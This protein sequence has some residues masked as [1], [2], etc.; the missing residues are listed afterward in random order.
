M[1]V[2]SILKHILSMRDR[3]GVKKIANAAEARDNKLGTIES[4]R[5]RSRLWEKFKHLKAGDM[6][7][8]HKDIKKDSGYEG[9]S[10]QHTE[11]WAKPLTVHEVKPRSKEIVVR[12]PGSAVDHRL[13]PFSADRM[14]LSLEPTKEAL[15][16]SLS[17]E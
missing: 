11:L 17:R 10:K 14:K 15:A 13:S 2:A 4:E 12:V 9:I 16:N 7:F 1:N 6:V 8:I 3:E 5:E